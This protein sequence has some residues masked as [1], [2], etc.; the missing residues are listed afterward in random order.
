M[1]TFKA[2][3]LQEIKEDF[4]HLF[5][6]D[7]RYFFIMKDAEKAGI[8]GIIDRGYS[9][10]ETL[11]TVFEGYR[12]KIINKATIDFMMN[13]PF[14]LGFHEVWT[15]TRLQSWIKLLKR[16]ESCGV[17]PQLL[18]PSWD[19]DLTKIWFRQKMEKTND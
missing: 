14:S 2:I 8:Y 13:H 10:A 9:R 12:Y 16:F 11:M 7:T 3:D 19:N 17:E 5:R 15:W 6:T 4:P 18:P 1:I